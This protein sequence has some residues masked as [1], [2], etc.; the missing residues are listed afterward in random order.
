M[1]STAGLRKQLTGPRPGPN[2][3]LAAKGGCH[4]IQIIQVV[5]DD[6]LEGP[7]VPGITAD[8]SPAEYVHML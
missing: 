4:Q 8:T 2:T 1:T 6:G 5:L 7:I 3:L